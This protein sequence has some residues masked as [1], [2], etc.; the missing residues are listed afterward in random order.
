MSD[1]PKS[2]VPSAPKP[3]ESWRRVRVGMAGIAGMLLL[4]ALGSAMLDRLVL[5]DQN[6]KPAN[7]ATGANSVEIPS[8]PM[9]ELG[10]APGAAEPASPPK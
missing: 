5:E 3:S 4:L 8:E 6:G 9:A 1:E 10:V 7:A 2:A